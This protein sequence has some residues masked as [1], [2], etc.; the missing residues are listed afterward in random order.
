[1][2]VRMVKIIG[3][4][5]NNNCWSEHY[6][7]Y[8]QMDFPTPPIKDSTIRIK[9]DDNFYIDSIIYMPSHDQFL[10]SER[11]NHSHYV[12]EARMLKTHTQLL[13]NGWQH[14]ETLENFLK[15]QNGK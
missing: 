6:R 1:M 4:Y 12:P 15:E 2:R 10:L 11:V 7:L 3:Y 5:D 8:K 9:E 14:K 13:K